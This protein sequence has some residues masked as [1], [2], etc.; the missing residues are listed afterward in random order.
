MAFPG[1][2]QLRDITFHEY[3]FIASLVSGDRS[4]AIGSSRDELT[5]GGGDS[6]WA[7]CGP[8]RAGDSSARGRVRL[9][10]D[11]RFHR[12]RLSPLS[13]A[14]SGRRFLASFSRFLLLGRWPDFIDLV[15]IIGPYDT[16]RADLRCLLLGIKNKIPSAR[17]HGRCLL[18][19]I[20]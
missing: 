19:G 18:F 7:G 8:P 13:F 12:P 3:I 6:D 15:F 10:H 16:L 9:P 5:C 4:S 11:Q 17:T 20:R 14:L 2:A 1:S